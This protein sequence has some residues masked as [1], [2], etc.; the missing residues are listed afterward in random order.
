M[1]NLQVLKAVGDYIAI[2]YTAR[3]E[4]NQC[5]E[6]YFRFF[7]SDYVDS[8]FMPGYHLAMTKITHEGS[9]ADLAVTKSEVEAVASYLGKAIRQ[10]NSDLITIEDAITKFSKK[11]VDQGV[12]S[13]ASP[14]P[15]LLGG[16]SRR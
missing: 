10:D 4:N 8:K 14:L 5:L 13:Q 16:W 9:K 12:L 1:N 3:V 7:R 2:L 6:G 11:N 15:T